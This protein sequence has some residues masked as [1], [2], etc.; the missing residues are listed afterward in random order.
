M[1]LLTTIPVVLALLGS[2]L[3]AG[4]FFAFS[5]FI[6]Q[7]L[8]RLPA[9]AGIAAMQAIN[10]TV[11]NPLFLGTFM[12]TAAISALIV[13]LVVLN[14]STPGAYW[15]LAGA[16]LYIAGTFMVTVGGNVPL[17][18]KLADVPADQQE[19][20]PVWEH[21]LRRWTMFNTVRTVAATAAV[22]AFTTGLMERAG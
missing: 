3:I 11:L 19:A 8:A 4:V 17:N 2:A 14:L 16:V 1:N 22:L 10:V 9:P 6:M 13:V 18:N 5:N 7:A 20:V 21:Y 12:G 15:Y